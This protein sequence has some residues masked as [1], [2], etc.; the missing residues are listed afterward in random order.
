MEKFLPR[1]RQWR[2]APG[3]VAI[4][5]LV[6]LDEVV[7]FVVTASG[8]VLHTYSFPPMQ[9]LNVCWQWLDADLTARGKGAAAREAWEAAM[10]HVSK[11]LGELLF[12]PIAAHV[13]KNSEIHIAPDRMMFVAPL[14]LAQI[15]G[16]GST[17]R[18]LERNVVNYCE[19]LSVGR[20]TSPSKG[21]ESVFVA[22][23]S[24]ASARLPFAALESKAVGVATGNAI[25][26]TGDGATPNAVLD[27]V[28]RHKTVHLCC[29]GSW[30]LDDPLESTL[31]LAGRAL[32]LRELR[33]RLEQSPC[34]LVVLS[35]CEVG[36]RMSTGA[37]ANFATVLLRA[38]CEAVIGASWPVDDLATTLLMARFYEAW[39]GKA[40]GA[41]AAL[42][43]AQRWLSRERG[44]DLAEQVRR[45][46][47][48]APDNS[49]QAYIDSRVTALDAFGE[50]PPFTHPRHWAAFSVSRRS[51]RAAA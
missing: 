40:N 39:N 34:E 4:A 22:A 15:G 32:T 11:E 36:R 12:A 33:F 13:P 20:A 30:S 17:E 46:T 24:P 26:I 44:R 29:H 16:A 50:E 48:L 3:H 9:L 19:Y 43:E 5:F 51:V 37:D 14:S 47:A 10:D 8:V 38:G 27:G 2:T 23:Y 31:V 41:P 1:A 21:D 25:V 42:R 35:A 45:L 6:K 49:A 18:L 28:A 7:A